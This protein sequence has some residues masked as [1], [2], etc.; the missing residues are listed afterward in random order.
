MPITLGEIIRVNRSRRGWTQAELATKIKTSQTA[1]SQMENYAEP[2]AR[3][4]IDALLEVFNYP[5]E[6]VTWWADDQLAYLERLL[7]KAHDRKR[8]FRLRRQPNEVLA[9][10]DELVEQSRHVHS[11]LAD[12]RELLQQQG[13]PDKK[14][15]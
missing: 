13:K 7:S 6:L 14:T 5:P 8:K 3:Q 1:V 12:L 4:K 11:E 9:K 15:S 2:D 10:L